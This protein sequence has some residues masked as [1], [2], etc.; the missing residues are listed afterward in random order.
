M[1]GQNEG[2]AKVRPAKRCANAPNFLL[3]EAVFVAQLIRGFGDLFA[4]AFTSTRP[5]PQL[6]PEGAL[7][8]LIASASS[9]AST[10]SNPSPTPCRHTNNAQHLV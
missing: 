4:V 1:P 5:R 8:L 3:T 7:P 10:H 2:K 6:R 9:S